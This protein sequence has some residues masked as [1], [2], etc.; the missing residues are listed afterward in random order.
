MCGNEQDEI[1][2]KNRNCRK[3]EAKCADSG[4]MIGNYRYKID[5]GCSAD[6]FR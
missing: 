5:H 3:G 6:A 4:M 2:A 1:T